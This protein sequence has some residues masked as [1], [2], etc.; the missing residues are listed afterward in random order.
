[1]AAAQEKKLHE[2]DGIIRTMIQSFERLWQVILGKGFAMNLL[3]ED[4]ELSC[5]KF[6]ELNRE[7]Q[8]VLE[9]LGQVSQATTKSALKEEILKILLNRSTVEKEWSS[10]SEQ[11]V[12]RKLRELATHRSELER[13]LIQV[14]QENAKFR[15]DL[16]KTMRPNDVSD[17]MIAD[18]KRE[19]E[20]S[21]HRLLSEKKMSTELQTE[22]SSIRNSL[23][24]FQQQ[25]ERF[26]REE[27]TIATELRSIHILLESTVSQRYETTSNV[28]RI[29]LIKELLEKKLRS[30]EE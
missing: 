6:I 9:R 13:Q 21:H 8:R 22:L 19:L 30:L 27:K 2:Q 18:L 17:R 1:M 4:T 23:L 3:K 11:E 20:E 29:H 7:L 10:I 5:T 15:A 25:T 12:V 14:N 26:S 16:Q 24:S 28:E